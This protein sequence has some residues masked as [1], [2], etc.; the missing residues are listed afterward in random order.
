M[1]ISP[2]GLKIIKSLI[3]A[4]FNHTTVD[5]SIDSSDSIPL[6]I[7]DPVKIVD[8]SD[9]YGTQWCTKATSS[10]YIAGIV[11][12]FEPLRKY[13]NQTY[14]T[15]NTTRT[16]YICRDPFLVLQAYVNAVILDTDIGK[17]LNIDSGTGNTNTGLSSVALDY[18]SLSITGGQFRIS[19]IITI[20]NTYSIVEVIMQKHEVLP[21]VTSTSSNDFYAEELTISINGQT[22]FTL[23]YVPQASHDLVLNQGVFALN[24]VDFSISGTT[25]TWL[26]PIVLATTDTLVARYYI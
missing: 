9:S 14:R 11:V 17:F 12:A 5:F 22:T 20:A 10:D 8:D 4:P 15:A 2:F 21:Y 13:E 18:A 3:G 23:S 24:G 7:N 1:Q 25:L 26:N 16:A 6:F 19:K